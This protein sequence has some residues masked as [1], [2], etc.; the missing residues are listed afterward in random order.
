MQVASVSTEPSG[1]LLVVLRGDIDFT[2]SASVMQVVRG[3]AVNTP[4]CDIRVDLSEVS[5]MDSS[6]IGVLVQL[7]NLAEEWGVRLRLEHPVSKVT[8]QLQMA[9]L[10]ELFG[11]SPAASWRAAPVED[12]P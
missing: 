12:R 5:F 4:R 6:G 10:A 1:E 3:G 2:S 7:L 11:L 8:D 9:G